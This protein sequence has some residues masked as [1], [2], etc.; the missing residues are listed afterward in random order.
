MVGRARAPVADG[1]AVLAVAGVDVG[2]VDHEAVM[3]NNIATPR[4]H[5]DLARL[6][7]GGEP[8]HGLREAYHAHPVRPQPGS[9]RAA[10]VAQ[11]A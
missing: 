3:R 7:L 2:A 5:R 9:V 8:G 11:A 4:H 6:V 10:D 1:A